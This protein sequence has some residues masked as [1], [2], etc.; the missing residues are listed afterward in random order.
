MLR[1]GLSLVLLIAGAA[2]AA[3]WPDHLGKYQLKSQT[4]GSI[5]DALAGEQGLESVETGDYGTFQAQA[6]RFKD[7]TGAFAA[8]LEVA[9]GALAGNYVVKCLSGACPRDLGALAG[10]YLPKVSHTPL[11]L[12]RGY[13]PENSLIPHSERYIL[14]P[15]GL[16]AA[17]PAIPAEPAAFPLGTEAAVAQYRTTQSRSGAGS[18]TL[19]ILSY[20]TPQ[21]ARQQAQEF[22][23]LPGFLVKRS[24]PLVAVIPNAA[25]RGVADKLLAG[26]EYQAKVTEYER[27]PVAVKA[28]TVAQMVLAIFALAGIILGFCLFSGLAFGGFR[29]LRRRFGNADAGG[30][31]IVLDLRDK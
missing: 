31:M 9:G 22:E 30:A 17:A 5:T 21:M 24:G 27:V 15:R 1:R 8:S 18:A 26:I 25:D 28:Q 10:Q 29:V 7:T 11:P 12:L 16:A 3:I 20:A 6:W 13:L 14:G 23:K 4:P 19:A 2:A